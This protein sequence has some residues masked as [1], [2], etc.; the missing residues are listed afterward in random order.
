MLFGAQVATMLSWYM[1]GM[2]NGLGQVV[3]ILIAM[4]VGGCVALL[5]GILKVYLNINEVIT[6]IM[7]NWIVYYAGSYMLN[8]VGTS[9]GMINGAGTATLPIGTNFQLAIQGT[10]T[11]A[12]S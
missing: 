3:A 10:G 5:V 11:A 4:L 7:F 6:C 12:G 9:M 1:T 8:T 2:P